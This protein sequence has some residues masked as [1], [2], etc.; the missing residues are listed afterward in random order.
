[1]PHERAVW[2][3][4]Q[5]SCVDECIEEGLGGRRIEAP[6]PPSLRASEPKPGHLPKLTLDP[7]QRFLDPADG[8]YAL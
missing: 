1:M 7:Q 5:K 8:L 3:A 6:Q 4:G 2:R